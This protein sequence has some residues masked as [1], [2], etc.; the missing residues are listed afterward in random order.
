MGQATTIKSAVGLRPRFRG[1][2]VSEHRTSTKGLVE[3][4]PA[5]SSRKRKGALAW[6]CRFLG[7]RC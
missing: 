3:I 6:L 2:K 5:S 4:G 7:S 1:G